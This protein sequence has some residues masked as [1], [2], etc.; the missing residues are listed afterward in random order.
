M[1]TKLLFFSLLLFT[2]ASISTSEI[3]KRAAN[4]S[5]RLPPNSNFGKQ[6]GNN[7]GNPS[8]SSHPNPAN[9]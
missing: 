8:K 5:Y 1:K 7:P 9:Q 3:P 2:T 4:G 6:T